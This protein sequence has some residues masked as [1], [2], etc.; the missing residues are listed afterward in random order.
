MGHKKLFE[1]EGVECEIVAGATDHKPLQ[2]V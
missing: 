2:V 1:G